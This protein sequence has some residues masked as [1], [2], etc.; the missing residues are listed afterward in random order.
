[1]WRA[2][3][4]SPRVVFAA[5][6]LLTLWASP[7]ALIYDWALVAVPAVLLPPSRAFAVGWAALA[8]GTEVGMA[9]AWA[10]GEPVVQLATPVLAWCGW[11]TVQ[12]LTPK[13]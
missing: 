4:D 1:M 2:N 7:H 12:L 8:V 9:Q 6:V 13:G 5:S 11:R 3:R 10:W